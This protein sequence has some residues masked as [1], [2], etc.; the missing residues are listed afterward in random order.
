MKLSFIVLVILLLNIQIL[1]AQQFEVSYSETA[2]KGP[3]TGNV[4]LYL[5]KESNEPKNLTVYPCFRME[6][7]NI[8]PNQNVTF[9]DSAISYPT[10]LSRIERGEYN[11]QV[12]WDLNKGG[13]IIGLSVDN[14][15]NDAVKI[16]LDNQTELFKITCDKVVPERIFVESKFVKEIK[17]PSKLLSKFY[18][19]PITINAPVILPKEYYEQ[20]GRMFPVY[21]IVAGYG[22]DYHHYSSSESSDTLASIPMDTIPCIKVYLDGNCPLGH[23]AYANSDNNGPVGDAFAYEFLPDLDKKFRTNGARVIRGHSSGGWTVAYLLTHYPKLFVAGNASAPDP[24]D[25]HQFTKTNLYKDS[26]RIEFVDALTI[27]KIPEGEFKYDLPNIAKS[28]E[29]VIYRGEQNV[30]FDAVFGPKGKNGLP[31]P[32]YNSATGVLNK[33]VFEH[34]KKYDLTQFLVSNW[35]KLERDLSGKMRFS[36]GNEDNAF[37]NFPVMM[38]EKEMKKVNA[39]IEFAYYP[40]NNFTVVT[41]NYKRDENAFLVKKYLEWLKNKNKKQNIY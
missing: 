25:F 10:L 19:K 32:L 7:K 3:F 16:K 21:F 13:R 8:K 5:S 38:L 15:Y 39:N 17:A 33:E 36:V 40:G 9:T 37:L 4:L 1:K 30:S 29:D 11:V 6:V 24:V 12:V 26:V 22:S 34:W 18:N 23:S 35:S 31:I 41:A 14:M 20:P 27:G 2:F 28:I